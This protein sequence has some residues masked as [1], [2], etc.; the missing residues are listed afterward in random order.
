MKARYSIGELF[1][2]GMVGSNDW[3]MEIMYV[4]EDSSGFMYEC[5]V[6]EDIKSTIYYSEDE[7]SQF[8]V[9]KRRV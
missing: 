7:I 8:F 5:M 4:E 1:T 3:N 6:D 9:K 2:R